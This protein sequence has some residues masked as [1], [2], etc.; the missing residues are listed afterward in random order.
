MKNDLALRITLD[1][2]VFVSVIFGWWFV[3][4]PIAIIGAWVFPRYAEAVIAGFIHDALF[5]IGGGYGILSYA[6]TIG[7]V[8]VISVIAYLKVVVKNNT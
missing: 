8:A 6:F 5:S 4:I 7:A 3:F 1:V 2:I